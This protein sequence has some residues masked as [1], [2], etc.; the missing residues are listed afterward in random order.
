MK[1]L[2]AVLASLCLLLSAFGAVAETAENPE[3]PLS[4]TLEVLNRGAEA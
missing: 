2:F 3:D 4:V 1:K